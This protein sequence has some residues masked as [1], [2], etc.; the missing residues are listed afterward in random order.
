M[1]FMPYQTIPF[2]HLKQGLLGNCGGSCSTGSSGND[3][4]IWCNG[5][6][7]FMLDGISY[8]TNKAWASY[9]DGSVIKTKMGGAASPE[10]ARLRALLR[11]GMDERAGRLG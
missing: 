5:P 4:W 11:L 8:S 2:R 3:K 10:P 6:C 7:N 1:L 9:D